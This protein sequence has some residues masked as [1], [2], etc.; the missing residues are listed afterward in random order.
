MTTLSLRTVWPSD[1]SQCLNPPLQVCVASWSESIWLP[2]YS[3]LHG[4]VAR[5]GG[6]QSRALIAVNGFATRSVGIRP[7]HAAFVPVTQ[8]DQC[9]VL[10]SYFLPRFPALLSTGLL[11]LWG[12]QLAKLL[13]TPFPLG[14]LRAAGYLPGPLCT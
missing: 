6:L 12:H 8:R 2:S 7:E 13:M 4:L 1:S 9:L 11:G 14:L 5:I 10:L 3:E